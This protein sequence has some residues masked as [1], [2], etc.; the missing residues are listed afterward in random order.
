MLWQT[1]G[2]TNIK[3]ILNKQLGSGV[4]PH[5]Y[6]FSGSSELGKKSLALELARKILNTEKLENHP[7]FQVLDADGEIVMEQVLDFI[8]KIGYKPFF[9]TKKVA[10]INN[11][12][13]LNIQSSNALL[14]TLEEPSPSSIII[15]ISSSTGLLPTIVSRCQVLNFNLF[16]QAGLKQFDQEFNL[17]ASPEMLEASFGRSGRLKKFAQDKDF[18]LKEK[19][20]IEEYQKITSQ[21][22]GEKL[23]RLADLAELEEA[24]LTQNLLS[25][26][27]WQTENLAHQPGD[28]F[29]VQAL[30]DAL[31]GLKNNQNKK[32]VLQSLMLK[33]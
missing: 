12:Q 25:W 28:F 30:I 18:F 19:G 5:A 24:S 20:V 9:G 23:S 3:N 29:R 15:L 33:I 6:L 32:L 13:N 16:S 1:F 7:D 26:L 8:G 10:I 31:S 17:Q 14:K 11:A 27:F 21:P 4:F 2:H 22:L